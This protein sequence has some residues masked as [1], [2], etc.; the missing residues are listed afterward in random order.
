MDALHGLGHVHVDV[1]PLD[2]GAC[3]E[4]AA[5]VAED[6]GHHFSLVAGVLVTPTH[7]VEVPQCDG[8][9]SDGR[10][11]KAAHGSDPALVEVLEK[12]EV[13]S[14]LATDDGSNLAVDLLAGQEECGTHAFCLDVLWALEPGIVGAVAYEVVHVLL[15]T[16]L[17]MLV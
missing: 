15:A 9:F 6:T 5:D 4:S 12:D 1:D 2:P 11:V 16:E 17:G 7:L 14:D 13:E 3:P 8:G 10:G